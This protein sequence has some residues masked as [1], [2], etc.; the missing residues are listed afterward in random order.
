MRNMV[1]VISIL[2]SGAASVNA[3]EPN[4]I[5]STV[6]SVGK[7]GSGNDKDLVTTIYSDGFGR[8]IQSKV[9]IDGGKDRVSCTFYDEAGRPDKTTKAFV[10]EVTP[11]TYL[12]KSFTELIDETNGQLRKQDGYNNDENPYFYTKYS[13]DP[14]SR[15]VEQNGPGE[16]FTDFPIK[17][18]YF[19]I[20]KATYPLSTTPSIQITDGLISTTITDAVLTALAGY[21]PSGE[22]D[23]VPDHFLAVTERVVLDDNGSNRSVFTQELKDIFGNVVATKAKSSSEKNIIAKY[24]F[25]ILG[26]L[27]TEIAPK[28]SG[29]EIGNT[30]Y[31]YNTL[32]LLVKKETPDGGAFGYA[33]TKSNQLEYDTS[34][35]MDGETKTTFRIRKYSYDKLDRLITTAT[36]ILETDSYDE[37]LKNYYDNTSELLASD[38][39]KY[40]IPLGELNSLTNL[41]GRM[42]ASVVKN[43]INGSSHYVADLFSYD[44]EGRTKR[45]LKIVPGMPVQYTGFKYDLQ[46]K[47]LSDTVMCGTDK[48][49]RAYCYDAEGRLEKV[50]HG[51]DIVATYHYDELSRMDKKNLKIGSTPGY[52]I[53]Y[54][55]NIREWVT[56]IASPVNVGF[57]ENVDQYAANGNIKKATYKYIPSASGTA[58]EHEL[59]YTYDDINRLTAVNAGVDKFDASY[60]YDEI[61]RIT[62][63][64][65]GPDD[66]K[67]GYAYYP[68]TNRLQKTATGDNKYYY[69]KHGN[70]VVDVNKRMTVEVDWRDMPVAFRFYNEMPAEL[71]AFDSRG[72]LQVDPR[73]YFESA[74]KTLLSQVIM[75]YDASGNRVLKM[76]GK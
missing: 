46:G 51:S 25:D 65:E 74:H 58:I 76:E 22:D 54:T 70:I 4:Y 3:V 20:K 1:F 17:T 15:V 24:E 52:D 32:G 16:D 7:D 12:S 47:L 43:S 66:P 42:V 13:D 73:T 9:M 63:K 31:V 36:K 26:N 28:P 27:I 44:D 21:T 6:Y 37:V 23:P 55:H 60:A 5:R 72:T 62:S 34:Y 2:I 50:K 18:Y 40:G 59:D 10:D 35:V 41:R 14:L 11:G 64:T 68:N 48:N 30:H 67:T 29:A 71:P 45:K 69:D 49:I 19:G 56:S 57:T 61:G 53:S 75:L 39:K 8:Q 38:A 33:Y